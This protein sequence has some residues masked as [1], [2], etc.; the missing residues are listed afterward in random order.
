MWPFLRLAGGIVMLILI[1]DSCYGMSIDPAGARFLVLQLLPCHR[2]RPQT[3]VE[4]AGKNIDFINIIMYYYY[5][6]LG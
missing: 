2:L 4:A 5:V 1:D 3:S 6:L